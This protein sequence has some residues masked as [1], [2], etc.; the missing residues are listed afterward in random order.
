M[1]DRLLKVDL[2]E[3][4]TA[5]GQIAR[6]NEEGTLS[7]APNVYQAVGLVVHHAF[8]KHGVVIPDAKT[9]QLIISLCGEHLEAG[10]LVG[11]D[12]TL[13]FLE[14]NEILEVP[15]AG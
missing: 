3:F 9:E 13:A 2:D 6:S 5:I 4:K 7:V 14:D 11:V 15:D 10:I 1:T 8:R 12:R